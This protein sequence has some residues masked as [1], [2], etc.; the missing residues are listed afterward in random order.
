MTRRS[1]S[2]SGREGRREGFFEMQYERL[3]LC[4]KAVVVGLC[5]GSK[6]FCDSL[7]HHDDRLH[8]LVCD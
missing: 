2:D 7:R 3:F 8:Q 1:C 4:V 6:H 5:C